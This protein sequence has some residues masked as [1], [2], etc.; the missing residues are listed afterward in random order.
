MAE[1]RE[2][3]LIKKYAKIAEETR[4]YLAQF[5]AGRIIWLGPGTDRVWNYDERGYIWEPWADKFMNIIV[6]SGIPIFRG[7]VALLKRQLRK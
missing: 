1:N 6:Q 4:D 3:P 5:K 2:E 7:G